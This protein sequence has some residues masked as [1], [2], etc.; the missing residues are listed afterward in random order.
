MLA[1]GCVV[2][3]LLVASSYRAG[4]QDLPAT[5][6]AP[7]AQAVADG[8]TP[9]AQVPYEYPPA[10]I[11]LLLAPRALGGGSPA[12]YHQRMIWLY[13]GI[14]VAIVLLLGH[15]L[16][17][18]PR[19]LA[20]ALLVW[21]ACVLGLGRVSLTRFDI[22]V[23][24]AVLAA[25]LAL[26]RRPRLAG[27]ALGLAAALKIGPLAGVAGLPRRAWAWALLLPVASQLA[28]AALTGC[29]G[30]SWVRYH[31]DRSP[32]LESW[33]AVVGELAERA[34]L[35]H[36]RIG[37]DHGSWNVIG[38]LADIAGRLSS[39]ALVA[40]AVL[41]ARRAR[42]SGLALLAALGAVVAFGSVLSPQYLLW[43]APLS[44]LLSARYPLQAM[45]LV[46]SCALTRLELWLTIDDLPSL[47][48]AGLAAIAAR[49]AVL[50]GWL[51][52]VYR[53]SARKTS[54]EGLRAPL[55]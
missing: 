26:E 24:L 30:L 27:L 23:G 46:A 5:Y 22:V 41:V 48:G 28:F 11:P 44:A 53:A 37:F 49:N 52:V 54:Q 9:Y 25:G 55:A 38:D 16:R 18:R 13:A 14:D 50:L 39:V 43:L 4:T 2:V 12:S 15:V 6:F 10:T 17:R 31:L 35:A 19:E 33:A 21:S 47:S 45:L 36:A 20:G 40:V 29:W 42:P 8:A 3:H 1:L 51:C 32:Q 7:K 34:G